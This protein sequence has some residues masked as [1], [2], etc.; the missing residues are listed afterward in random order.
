MNVERLKQRLRLKEARG[1][2]PERFPYV[3]SEGYLTIGFGRNLDKVGVREDEA[4]LMLSNDIREAL[5]RCRKAFA[6]FEELNE[7]RQAVVV[8]MCFNL[9]IGGLLMFRRMIAALR[10]GDYEKAADEM[11]DSLWADQVGKRADEAA[12]MMREGVWPWD[13]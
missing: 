7:V 13:A 2:V 6:F 12:K 4:E 5:N 9:G 8:E 10:V 11:L 3:D 1:G